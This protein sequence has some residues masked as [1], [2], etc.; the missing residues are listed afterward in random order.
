MC[1]LALSLHTVDHLLSEQRRNEF[2][3]SL[4]GVFR[5]PQE[6]RILESIPVLTVINHQLCQCLLL[7]DQRLG[8]HYST[9]QYSC[10]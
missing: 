5:R 3:S 1:Q 4:N 7:D 6:E 8:P 10:H 2:Q 9:L